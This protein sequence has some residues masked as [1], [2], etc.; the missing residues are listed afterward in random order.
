M[1]PFKGRSP[2]TGL[3][4]VLGEMPITVQYT[5]IA[6]KFEPKEKIKTGALVCDVSKRIIGKCVRTG[7]VKGYEG[8]KVTIKPI[9]QRRHHF[10]DPTQVIAL[11][12]AFS[13]VR[14]TEG[15]W[16]KMATTNSKHAAKLFQCFK[17]DTSAANTTGGGD[18][19]AE[20]TGETAAENTD[21][22][23]AENTGETAVE[24]TAETAA[25]NTADTAAE[26]TAENAVENAAENAVENA[27]ENAAENA[28]GDGGSTVPAPGGWPRANVLDDVVYVWCLMTFTFGA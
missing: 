7:F 24:N 26:N 8:T 2:P 16:Y 13:F 10:A 1:E 18:E 3:G 17:K 5:E 27:A 25:E 12:A 20:N 9:G 4:Y 23:A 14:D 22:T 21:E 28:G 19:N 11:P 6:Q 15:C